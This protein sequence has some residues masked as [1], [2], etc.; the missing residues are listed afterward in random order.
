MTNNST[1]DCSVATGGTTLSSRSEA[2]SR[3][4]VR[5]CLRDVANLPSDD[6]NRPDIVQIARR[7]ASQDLFVRT[8][9]VKDSDLDL[10]GR[11]ATKILKW[12]HV[13]KTWRAA[14]W[15]VVKEPVRKALTKRRNTAMCGIKMAFFG[16]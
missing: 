14:T 8:K 12:T 16:R 7:K 6:E 10:N 11:V 2:S 3:T 1:A 4:E 5:L 9:F 15:G 13:K